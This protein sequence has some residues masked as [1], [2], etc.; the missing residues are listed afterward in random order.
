VG[1]FRRIK[2]LLTPHTS[3]ILTCFTK[4]ENPNLKGSGLI[5]YV[6]KT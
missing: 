3:I 1:Y 5:V 2:C 4:Y 6:A